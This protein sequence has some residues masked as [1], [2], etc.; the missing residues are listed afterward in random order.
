MTDKRRNI[1]ELVVKT[2]QLIDPT[3]INAKKYLVMF[4]EMS[5]SQFSKWI[6]DFLN[7][8]KS[9]FRLDIEEF[10]D[11]SRVLKFENVDKAAKFLNIPLFEH[12]YIP[13]ISADPN[14]PIRTKQPVLVGY[15]NI[16]RVQQ[17]V[18]KKTGLTLSDTDRDDLSGVLKGDAKGGC[19]TAIEN[20]VLAGMGADQVMSEFL[21]SRAEN[22][23]EYD[24][25][26]QSIAE[27]GKVRL[28]DI[29][30]GVYDKPSLLLSDIYFM[31]MGIKT[32]IVS[33]AYYSIDQVRSIMGRE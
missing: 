29:K 4:N 18:T 24:N 3:G 8:E 12:V 1:Q 16:K 27:T 30:T 20:E 31:C 21:G 10:G 2:M 17:L 28:E 23:V 25:M 13:H 22:V 19:M 33:E 11:G 26:I 7:D 15:L 5:D 6:T 9:N 14:H 32:D